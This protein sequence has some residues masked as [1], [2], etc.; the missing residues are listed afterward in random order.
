MHPI[1]SLC[2]ASTMLADILDD[3]NPPRPGA[4]SAVTYAPEKMIVY[5]VR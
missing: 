5:G 1:T 4:K 2:V 3:I